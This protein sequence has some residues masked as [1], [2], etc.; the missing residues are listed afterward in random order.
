MRRFRSTSLFT[1]LLIA[2]TAGMLALGGCSQESMTGPTPPE[3]EDEV[4]VDGTSK[5]SNDT[6]TDDPQGGHNH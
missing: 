2:L 3:T 6:S 5:T 1:T 4:K